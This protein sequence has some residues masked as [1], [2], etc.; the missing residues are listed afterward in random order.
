MSEFIDVH[1][2][3]DV[4]VS[5][6]ATGRYVASFVWPELR[7][8]DGYIAHT[9]AGH[10][11][12]EFNGAMYQPQT[13]TLSVAFKQADTD[14][15]HEDIETVTALIKPGARWYFEPATAARG[16]FN[17]VKS[18]TH[19]EPY[20]ADADGRW[21]T[22]IDFSIRCLPLWE[23]EEYEEALGN[24]TNIPG[25]WEATDVPGNA[26]AKLRLGVTC[27]QQTTGMWLGG[28]HAPHAD[29]NPLQDYQGTADANARSGETSN[30]T[31]DGDMATIG[32]PTTLDRFAD[33]A[34]VKPVIRVKQADA[35]PADTTYRAQ[36]AVVGDGINIE[37]TFETDEVKAT[38]ATDFEVLTLQ[39]VPIPA[40]AMPGETTWSGY[41]DE[42]V[43]ESR[44]TAISTTSI[45]EGYWFSF[46]IAFT[47]LS[48]GVTVKLKETGSVERSVTCEL[49][50]FSGGLPGSTLY[51]TDTVTVAADTDGEVRF[52]WPTT[53]EG[54]GETYA[55]VVY[56]ADATSTSTLEIYYDATAGYADGAAGSIYDSGY[57]AALLTTLGVIEENTGGTDSGDYGSYAA[58]VGQSFTLA[59]PHMVTGIAQYVI[60]ARNTI[61][62]NL[63]ETSAGLPTGASLGSGTIASGGS[64]PE[65]RTSDVGL[66]SMDAGLMCFLIT[67]QPFRSYSYG[68]NDYADGTKIKGGA[69]VPDSDLNFKIYGYEASARDVYFKSHTKARLGFSCRVRIQTKNS[70]GGTVKLDTVGLIP[71]DQW[72]YAIIHGV[73]ANRGYLL[74]AAADDFSTNRVYITDTDEGVA[75]LDQTDVNAIGLMR[76]WPGDTSI[77]FMANTP[78]DEAPGAATATA[79]ITPRWTTPYRGTYSEG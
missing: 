23:D 5:N 37:K 34:W 42:S 4:S 57:I 56:L 18:V 75:P 74:D 38:E 35:T 11:E 60:D 28:Y 72:A 62:L 31:A 44:L 47:E 50:N 46:P 27:A 54:D 20:R 15:L 43:A 9:A 16:L 69:T 76:L 7:L 78:G 67:G 45:K 2:F 17:T 21:I 64:T 12:A 26:P 22:V 14:A 77:V 65:W 48:T 61:D 30:V 25:V 49:R 51:R 73:T 6:P 53:F 40:G 39:N 59:T 10:T 19:S 71:Q 70:G 29:Y 79:Y 58:N 3:D 66:V 1:T 41:D 52:T 33:E 24:I 63:Y 13:A 32:T 68:G 8:T 36:S 55:A